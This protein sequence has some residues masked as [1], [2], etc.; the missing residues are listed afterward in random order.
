M[1]T[2]KLRI[3]LVRVGH[4]KRPVDISRV[5]RWRSELFEVVAI[6]EISH[7]PDGED[8][9]QQFSDTSRGLPQPDSASDITIAV[10]EYSLENN[11]YLRRLPSGLVLI[12]LCEIRP[13]LDEHDVPL[14]NFLV[15]NIY[16]TCLLYHYVGR[17]L[18][19]TQAGTPSIMHDETRS[20]L[21][22]MNGIRSDILYSTSAPTICSA[23]DSQLSTTQLPHET[24]KKVRLELRKIRKSLYFRTVEFVKRRPILSLAIAFAGGLA[25]ELIG[26]ASYDVLRAFADAK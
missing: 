21:F 25:L 2:N 3:S 17:R 1:T 18:P 20:C 6:K 5:Q 11:Y 4:F 14:E 26:N 16:S 19:A 13:L 24:L 22:D 15:R 10:T 12:S 9:W 23:C 7:S 8:E